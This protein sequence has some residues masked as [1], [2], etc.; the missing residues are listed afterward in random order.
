[1]SKTEDRCA[2]RRTEDGGGQIGAGTVSECEADVA[3]ER[4]GDEAEGGGLKFGDVGDG[5]LFALLEHERELSVVEDIVNPGVVYFV[6][7]EV[8]GG[9]DGVD[10][11]LG[12]E[13]GS[14]N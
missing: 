2:G 8:T 11:G 9:P 1:M 5:G 6:G 12:L 14:Q 13:R 4:V 7:D 3:G 10:R